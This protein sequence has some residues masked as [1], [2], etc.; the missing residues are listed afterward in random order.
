MSLASY[1]EQI[2]KVTVL[3]GKDSQGASIKKSTA[4]NETLFV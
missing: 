2:K 3:H 4:M 1:F